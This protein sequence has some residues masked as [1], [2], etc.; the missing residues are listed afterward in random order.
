MQRSV[1]V[2]ERRLGGFPALGLPAAATLLLALWWPVAVRLARVWSSEEALSHGPLLVLIA[3]V[4]LWLRRRSFRLGDKCWTPG[5]ALALAGGLIHVLAVWADIEFLKPLSLL[6]LTAGVVGYLAG[7]EACRALAAPLGLLVFTIPWPTTLVERIAFPLQLV[8]SAY[9]ALFAGMLGLPIHREGVQLT[10][11]SAP[12]GQP[13]YA[14]LVAR[15]CSGLASLM[16]LLALGYLV[17]ACT[18]ASW[19]GRALLLLAVPPLALFTNA[20]RLTL[21]LLAGAHHSEALARWVHDH[22]APVLVFL[23]SLALLALR[24]GVLAATRAQ[25]SDSRG[26]QVP[27]SSH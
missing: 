21:I 13:V 26:A 8:S 5:W 2:A 23:S 6:V 25:G 20:I 24:H 18:P 12:D 15:Q 16:V 3:G 7:A 4:Q 10:V 17:A 27:V 19:V 11:L 1:P 9:A 14:I 22:E